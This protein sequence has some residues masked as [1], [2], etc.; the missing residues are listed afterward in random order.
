M[1]GHAK[2]QT[3][4]IYTHVSPKLLQGAASPFDS[5]PVIDPAD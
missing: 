5:L 1:L 2:L 4:S 3:T